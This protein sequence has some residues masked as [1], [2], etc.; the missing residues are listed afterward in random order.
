[1]IY[2]FSKMILRRGSRYVKGDREHVLCCIERII[3]MRGAS[4][5]HAWFK[6]ASSEGGFVCR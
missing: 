3:T 5:D 2:S 1:M 6:K 4:E